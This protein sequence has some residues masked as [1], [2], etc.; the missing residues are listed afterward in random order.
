[1]ENQFNAIYENEMTRVVL[2]PVLRDTPT[3]MRISTLMS[4]L[5]VLSCF[6]YDLKGEL[7][8]P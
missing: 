4:Y 6:I 3:R 1:M 8:F 7:H 5:L 2:D